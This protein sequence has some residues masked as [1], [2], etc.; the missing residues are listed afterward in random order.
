MLFQLACGTT[1]AESVGNKRSA[2]VA[3]LPTKLA[4][5]LVAPQLD[6]AAPS[7]RLVQS[8]IDLVLVW[9][10]IRLLACS[11]RFYKRRCGTKFTPQR[12]MRPQAFFIS[13][14]CGTEVRGWKSVERIVQ[15]V[16]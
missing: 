9:F 7:T 6:A 5:M 14:Y 16:R 2:G 1:P 12:R 15:E 3:F 8:I 4:P 13:P 10:F 11:V